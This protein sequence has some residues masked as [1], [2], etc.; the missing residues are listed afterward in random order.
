MFFEQLGGIGI[1]VVG[2][3]GLNNSSTVI[4]IMTNVPQIEELSKIVDL[5]GI[6]Y[7]PAIYLT[8]VGSLVIVLALVGGGGIYA[9]HKI[10]ISVVRTLPIVRIIWLV[11]SYSR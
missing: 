4:N 11:I 10:V 8:V 9:K 2:G 5:S 6:A 3:L 7:G 1:L